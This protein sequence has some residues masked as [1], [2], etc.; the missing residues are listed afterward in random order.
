ML[1][2][3]P[4]QA[5]S[6]ALMLGTLAEALVYVIK[7]NNTA[8]LQVVTGVGQLLQSNAPVSSVVLNR[9]NILKA[10]KQCC[11]YAGYYGNSG[12]PAKG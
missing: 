7:S 9:V 5:V 11:N 1:D 4:T 6:D 10:N 2:S 12:V 8:I 3:P